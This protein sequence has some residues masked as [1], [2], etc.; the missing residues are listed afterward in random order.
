MVHKIKTSPLTIK[1]IKNNTKTLFFTNLEI[2]KN[3]IIELN[4]NE[5]NTKIVAKDVCDIIE[6]DFRCYPFLEYYCRVILEDEDIANKINFLYNFDLPEYTDETKCQFLF[7]TEYLEDFKNTGNLP[8]ID[9]I[10]DKENYYLLNTM[11]D[12]LFHG[13]NEWLNSIGYYKKYKRYV[14]IA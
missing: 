7:L 8:D 4:S 9:N 12:N 10:K 13:C 5:N 1:K 6:S 2:S 11:R 3:D 14:I